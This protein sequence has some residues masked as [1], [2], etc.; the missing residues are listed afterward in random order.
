MREESRQE[1]RATHL[2]LGDTDFELLIEACTRHTEGGTN[3]DVTIR[4]CWDAD[5]LD[6][7]RIGIRTDPRRLCTTAAR[8]PKLLGWASRQAADRFVPR[9]V[10]EEWGIDPDELGFSGRPSPA[11]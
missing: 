8:D 9:A 6:L 5:R 7:E 3:G 4:A 11:G 10:L 2:D 1:L